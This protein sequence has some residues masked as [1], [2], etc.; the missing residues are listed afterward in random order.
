MRRRCNKAC[1]A[2]S[3]SSHKLNACRAGIEPNT[4]EVRYENLHIEAS[5]YVG[6]RALPTVLNSYLNFFEVCKALAWL[7]CLSH[8]HVAA[9]RRSCHAGHPAEAA[10]AAGVQETLCHT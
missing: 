4:C 7:P 2:A 9:L 8:H 6:G 3:S 10:P 1:M 5:A